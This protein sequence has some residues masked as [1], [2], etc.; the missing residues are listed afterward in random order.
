MKNQTL[1]NC[2]TE[3]REPDWNDFDA[4]EIDCCAS[5]IFP[6]SSTWTERIPLHQAEFFTV[7]GHLKG[8]GCEAITDVSTR[9]LANRV[10]NIFREKIGMHCMIID[11]CES[12]MGCIDMSDGGIDWEQLR[13]A[14]V[15]VIWG[16]GRS[17]KLGAHN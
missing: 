13:A 1:Y 2:C 3:H 8:G 14:C 15:D 17:S 16:R 6:D 5:E 7:F 10:A 9:K 12:E 4:L 11:C